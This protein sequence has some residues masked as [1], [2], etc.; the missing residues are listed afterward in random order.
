MP[1][2]DPA[3]NSRPR[4]SERPAPTRRQVLARA[5]QIAL[6]GSGAAVLVGCGV[7]WGDIRFDDDE[8]LPT[9]GPG[10]DELA[11]RRAV[12]DAAALLALAL[13]VA[14][15]R[16]DLAPLASTV[17]D[18]HRAHLTSLGSSTAEEADTGIATGSGTHTGTPS[19]AA[20]STTA[21]SSSDA[22]ATPT[23]TPPLDPVARWAEREADAAARCLADLDGVSGGLARLLASIAAS[24]AVH[25]RLAA[26]ATGLPEPALPGTGPVPQAAAT[27][28]PDDTGSTTSPSSPTTAAP[29]PTAAPTALDVDDAGRAALARAVDGEH[30]AIYAYGVIGARLGETGTPRARDALEAHEDTLDRVA[31]LLT[32]SSSTAPA[33]APAYVLPTPITDPRGA[34]TAAVQLEERLATTYTDLVAASSAPVRSIAARLLVR[35]ALQAAYWRGHAVAFP[36]LPERS[37][38]TP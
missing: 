14:S 7:P 9:P 30:A 34:V 1:W 35:T 19:V 26:T 10:P 6:V 33:A 23:A 22:D 24:R 13:A 37:A 3:V 36:G 38:Q 12:T 16:T 5:V 25:A 18:H 32:R 11:R 21:G 4:P 2:D 29:A 8:P 31:A 20:T 17:A 28:A 15:A 27:P